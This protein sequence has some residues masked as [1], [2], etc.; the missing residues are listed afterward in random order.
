[1]SK[2]KWRSCVGI[3]F[4]L[5][6]S[7]QATRSGMRSRAP[8][9]HVRMVR[10][11]TERLVIGALSLPY[12]VLD[13]VLGIRPRTDAAQRGAVR[14]SREHEERP[15]PLHTTVRGPPA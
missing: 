3:A 9:S 14:R 6:V 2:L 11:G 15:N 1:M 5:G 10:R 7:S 12:E 8:S 4:T 13:E